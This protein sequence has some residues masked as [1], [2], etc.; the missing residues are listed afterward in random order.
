MADPPEKLAAQNPIAIVRWRGSTN[1]FRIRDRVEGTRVA[2]ATPRRARAAINIP[3]LVESAA[4][5]DAMPTT[6][7]PL[8]NLSPF[9]PIRD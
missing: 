8:G 4:T 5:I 7:A 9:V 2:A 6:S 1:M 3:A